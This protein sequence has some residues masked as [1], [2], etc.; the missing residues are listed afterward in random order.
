MD[1]HLFD[2]RNIAVGHA[3]HF[4]APVYPRLGALTIPSCSQGYPTELLPSPLSS[5]GHARAAQAVRFFG[6]ARKA[7]TGVKSHMLVDDPPD[8]QLQLGFPYDV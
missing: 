5:N 2:V 4:H 1:H 3:I 7:K 8:L 6:Q